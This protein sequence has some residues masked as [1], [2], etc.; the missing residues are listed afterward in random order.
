M[1][2]MILGRWS[3]NMKTVDSTVTKEWKWLF[4]NGIRKVYIRQLKRFIIFLYTYDGHVS[5]FMKPST[6][7][8][9]LHEWP[10]NIIHILHIF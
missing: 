5:V 7:S 3:N 6:L 4:V 2:E 1:E 10:A 8:L 9:H